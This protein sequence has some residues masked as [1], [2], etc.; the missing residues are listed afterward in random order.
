MNDLQHLPNKYVKQILF[1]AI[2][3]NVFFISKYAVK[4]VLKFLKCSF[5]EQLKIFESLN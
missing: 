5:D 1:Y 2:C 4:L 3:V